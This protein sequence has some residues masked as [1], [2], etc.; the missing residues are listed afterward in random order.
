MYVH[1][2]CLTITNCIVIIADKDHKS[3]HKSDKKDRDRKDRDKDRERKHRDKENG[4]ERKE[5]HKS[6][7]H[8]EDE[9]SLIVVKS[10][11]TPVQTIV[12]AL[13]C[14]LCISVAFMIH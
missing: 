9:V 2:H 14:I 13:Y 11:F 1:L 12:L 3:D 4:E 8:R 10:G 7:R 5:K 6:S